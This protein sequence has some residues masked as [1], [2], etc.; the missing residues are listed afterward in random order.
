M[1]RFTPTLL[2]SGMLTLC[3]CASDGAR[4]SDADALAIEREVVGVLERQQ[5][6]WNDGSIDD[7]LVGYLPNDRLTF[8]S[9][10]EVRRGFDATR[11]RYYERYGGDEEMGRLAFADF[12]VRVLAKDA[13]VVT[14]AWRL[15][16]TEDQPHGRFTLLFREL[17]GEWVIV[18]D[19]T[20]SA[21]E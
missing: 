20:S 19:H 7:F 13:A 16:R 10:A 11:R 3:G 5:A 15:Q 14:G 2:L 9:G 8:I 18:L 12:D 21:D 4:P 6:A 17:D 1:T